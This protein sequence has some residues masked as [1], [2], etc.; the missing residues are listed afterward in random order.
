MVKVGIW[1]QDDGLTEAVQSG[2]GQRGDFGWYR[3]SHPAELAQQRL[4]L[5]IISPTAQGWAGASVLECGTVLL[6]GRA[7][8]LLRAMHVESAVSYGPS[9][10][11]SI[12]LSSMKD[13][14]ICIAVQRELVTVSGGLVERQELVLPFQAASEEDPER[15]LAVTGALLLLGKRFF[16]HGT[17][18]AA[19]TR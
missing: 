5:L 11:D 10:K 3:A 17:G 18:N 9:A 8:S 14:H 2:L 1:G 15:F 19:A 13:G 7:G 12:T 16:V 6:P 4:K